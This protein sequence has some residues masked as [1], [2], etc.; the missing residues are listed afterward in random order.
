MNWQKLRR[1]LRREAREYL[2]DLHDIREGLRHLEGWLTLCLLIAVMFMVAVWFVT[3]LGFDRL[4]SLTGALGAWRPRICRPL[5]DFNAVALVIDSLVMMLLAIVT[6]GE[7]MR[8]LD[9]K[10]SSLPANYRTVAIPAFFMLLA[11]I[12]GIVY[13]R[14]IC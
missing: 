7:M 13:M 5:D 10:R 9:R 14:M 8:L 4:N 2:A 11:A 3:G 6:I 1:Q 12:A